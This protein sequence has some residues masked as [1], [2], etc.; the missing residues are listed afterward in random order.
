[1]E[2]EGN[3][4]LPFLELVVMMKGLKVDTKCTGNLLIL[5]VICTSSPTTH[6]T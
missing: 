1:M 3:D 6:I 2:V 4:T 5:V